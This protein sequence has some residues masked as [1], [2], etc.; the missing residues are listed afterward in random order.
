MLYLFREMV[1]AALRDRKGISALEYAI[2]A[3]AILGA[4]SVSIGGIGGDL[5]TIFTDIKGYLDTSV[6]NMP[7]P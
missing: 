4:I 7:K 5:S 1:I 3:A 6:S 2:L